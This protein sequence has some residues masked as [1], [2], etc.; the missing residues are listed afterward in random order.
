[1][2]AEVKWCIPP[3]TTL[4]L[5]CRCIH[6]RPLQEHIGARN[7]RAVARQKTKEVMPEKDTEM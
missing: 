1:M 7:E 5:A 3:I 4:S 6:R 2:L